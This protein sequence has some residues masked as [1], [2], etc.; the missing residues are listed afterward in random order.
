MYSI[1]HTE[2]YNQDKSVNIGTNKSL[3]SIFLLN[4][5]VFCCHTFSAN[6]KPPRISQESV[7]IKTSVK[8]PMECGC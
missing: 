5:L 8:I 2:R 6:V 7:E 4:Q 1:L 3:I